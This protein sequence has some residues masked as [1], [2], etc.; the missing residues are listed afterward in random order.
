METSKETVTVRVT[1]ELLPEALETI[2]AAV[3]RSPERPDP[4]DRVGERISQFL[5]DHDFAGYVARIDGP[6]DE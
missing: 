3:K 5:L 6:K 4:A 1:L 2:V